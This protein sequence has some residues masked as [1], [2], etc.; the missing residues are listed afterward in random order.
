MDIDC[1]GSQDCPNNADY[2]KQTAF[3]FGGKPLNAM[4]DRYIVMNVDQG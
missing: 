2:Q 1:D 4:T 3:Q